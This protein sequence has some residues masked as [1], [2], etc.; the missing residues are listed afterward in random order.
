MCS[1]PKE[2]I[3]I[4]YR[5]YTSFTIWGL[6]KYSYIYG[7]STKTVNNYVTDCN[8]EY[9]YRIQH[10]MIPAHNNQLIN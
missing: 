6:E 8:T 7:V 5:F 2:N 4:R 9:I 1:G 10:M 3:S